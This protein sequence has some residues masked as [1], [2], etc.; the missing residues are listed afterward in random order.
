MADYV[1]PEN[2]VPPNLQEVQVLNDFVKTLL[3]SQTVIMTNHQIEKFQE[4]NLQLTS[5]LSP[6]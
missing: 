3:V 6:L 5:L 1:N 2:P 4:K